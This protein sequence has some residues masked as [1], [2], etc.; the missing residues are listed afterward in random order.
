MLF[1]KE[2][3]EQINFETYFDSLFKLIEIIE[4]L[5]PFV[6]DSNLS[7]ILNN[8]LTE[9]GDSKELYK[10]IKSLYSVDN[11]VLDKKKLKKENSIRM[12]GIQETFF[13]N[14]LYNNRLFV[15][16]DKFIPFD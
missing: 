4:T 7:R 2:D 13:N 6:I 9:N 12:P 8:F 16:I 14:A 1:Q 11:N 5:K 10:T 3:N 15:D